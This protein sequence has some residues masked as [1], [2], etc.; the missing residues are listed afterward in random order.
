[1]LRETCRIPIGCSILKRFIHVLW[2]WHSEF[3]WNMQNPTLSWFTWEILQC[4]VLPIN[5]WAHSLFLS[6]TFEA[7]KNTKPFKLEI[8]M[9]IKVSAL[10]TSIKNATDKINCSLADYHRSQH[11]GWSFS[12]LFIYF[13]RIMNN[14]L[15]IEVSNAIQ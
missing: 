2:D 4:S 13:V 9:S 10:P 14:S 15:Y 5:I 1:M 6:L 8:E 12:T 7:L 11:L 3:N